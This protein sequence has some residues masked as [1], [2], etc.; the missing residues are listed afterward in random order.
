MPTGREL[1][2][3]GQAALHAALDRHGGI[4]AVAR[5]LGLHYLSREHITAYTAAIVERLARSIQPLAES[6]LL[7]GA[8]VMI[9]QR[10]AAMLD[11]R[12]PRLTRLNASLARGNHDAIELALAQL[13]NAPVAE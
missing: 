12:Q 9:I 13:I 4:S 3:A 10:P 5:S 1:R 6:N 2:K 7:S 8:R 11:Y